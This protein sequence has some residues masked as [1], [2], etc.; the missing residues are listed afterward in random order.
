MSLRRACSG[1]ENYLKYYII[2]IT[3][4]RA[5]GRL[6]V[7]FVPTRLGITSGFGL[8]ELLITSALDTNSSR[9]ITKFVLSADVGHVVFMRIGLIAFDVYQSQKRER[10]F[11]YFLRFTNCKYAT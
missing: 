8:G 11:V 6:N 5:T 7:K 3:V 2:V 10:F 1:P 4:Y 9:T